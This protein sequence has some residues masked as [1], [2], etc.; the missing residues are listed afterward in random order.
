MTSQCTNHKYRLAITTVR[1]NNIIIQQKA[2]LPYIHGMLIIILDN[3]I[4][5]LKLL[6]KFDNKWKIKAPQ[7]GIEDII[8]R[9]GCTRYQVVAA[10]VTSLFQYA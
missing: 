2:M 6:S 7:K 10:I 3:K 5:R 8:G 4:L 1:L 9:I